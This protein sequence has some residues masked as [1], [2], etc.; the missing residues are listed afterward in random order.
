MTDKEEKSSIP[1]PSPKGDE[2]LR[3]KSKLFPLE[4]VRQNIPAEEMPNDLQEQLKAL[5][6]PKSAFDELNAAMKPQKDLQE[7][8]KALATSR[9]QLTEIKETHELGKLIRK[10]RGN[11]GMNQQQLADLAG[12]GRRFLSELENGKQSLEFGK[13]LRVVS[14]VGIDL[15]AKQR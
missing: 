1:A 11:N 3:Q 4:S 8:L 7:K 14:A 10:R 5:A 6:L 12:V 9:K 15:L 13:V 2:A